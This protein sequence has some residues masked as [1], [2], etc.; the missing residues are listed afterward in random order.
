MSSK[1]PT[2]G[3][4]SGDVSKMSSFKICKSWNSNNYLALNTNWLTVSL[5]ALFKIP[6]NIPDLEHL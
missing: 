1:L 2:K 4:S 6:G 5:V 3:L